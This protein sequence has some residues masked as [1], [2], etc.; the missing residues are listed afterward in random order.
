MS[1]FFMSMKVVQQVRL[2]VLLYEEC[3][4]P[5][6]FNYPFL[7]SCL[8]CVFYMVVIRHCVSDMSCYLHHNLP[9]FIF[10]M[11]LPPS[12]LPLL[13]PYLSCVYGHDCCIFNWLISKLLLCWYC[14]SDDINMGYYV[15][16]SHWCSVTVRVL[17][18]LCGILLTPPWKSQ[19][20]KV[21]SV[22]RLL[23]K[24]QTIT[25]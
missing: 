10:I 21:S 12:L 22:L 16:F 19:T 6:P 9:S 2:V 14:W 17:F 23:R 11:A 3:Q 4:Q 13:S 20:N 8:S 5:L 24:L 25:T 18:T 7:H 1:M 15:V